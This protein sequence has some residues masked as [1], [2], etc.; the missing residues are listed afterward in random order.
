MPL[1]FVRDDITRIKADV[2]VNA[3]ND[4][5][6]MG[7]GVCGAIFRAA[8]PEEL[9]AAC[10]AIGSCPTGSAV[11][12]PGFALSRYIVHAVGPVW[13]GG[14]HGEAA[15]LAGCYQTALTLAAKAEAHSIAFPLISAGIYG[16]PREEAL[17]IAVRTIRRFL[18]EMDDEPDVLLVLFDRL[19]F[20]AGTGIWGDIQS[21]LDENDPALLAA[22]KERRRRILYDNFPCES[23]EADYSLN[24][25]CMD[26][27]WCKAPSV[28]YAP[29]AP[30]MN[31]FADTEDAISHIS[32]W[33]QQRAPE[34][35]F[36]QAL[37]HLID[38]CGE[39][40]SVIYKRAN[41]DRRLFSKIRSIKGYQPS[42]STALALCLA[43]RLDR[44]KTDQLLKKAGYALTDANRR[45]QVIIVCL[46]RHYYDVD[47]INTV[48]WNEDLPQL[49]A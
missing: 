41:I 7:G 29:A 27:D 34:E 47:T 42:K 38:E 36:A 39:K 11:L 43:L 28:A 4:H 10:Q 24:E 12:T 48:L 31:T 49:G 18:S 1:H 5:L 14:T 33:L 16:Y 35:T 25:P 19:S 3:A 15:L 30:S 9:T 46:D 8:G 20:D 23:E 21:Y 13:Q 17:T 40:D 2:I 22:A 26:S 32:D 45:D 37:L 6:R 44:A